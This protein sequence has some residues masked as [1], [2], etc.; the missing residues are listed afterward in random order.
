M[1]HQYLYTDGS[2]DQDHTQRS[3]GDRGNNLAVEVLRAFKFNE[4]C[5]NLVADRGAV[6]SSTTLPW[7]GMLWLIHNPARAAKQ[8]P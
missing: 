3:S 1:A 5:E 6:N 8:Y 2:Q 4:G 7:Q